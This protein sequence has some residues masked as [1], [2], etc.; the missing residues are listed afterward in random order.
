MCWER[1]SGGGRKGGKEEK[2]GDGRSRKEINEM[3]TNL[4]RGNEEMRH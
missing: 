1:Q 4:G 3:E 2:D